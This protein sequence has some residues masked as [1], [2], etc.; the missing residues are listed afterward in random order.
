M[1]ISIVIPIYNVEAYLRECLNS[2]MAQTCPDWECILIDDASTDGS[3]AIADEFCAADSRFRLIT[4][5]ENRGL[6]EARNSGLDAAKGDYVAFIDSDDYVSADFLQ[7]SLEEIADAEIVASAFD[8]TKGKEATYSACEALS[9]MLYQRSGVNSSF[10]GKLF[11]IKLFDSLRF[12]PGRTYE[13]LDLMDRVVRR[14]R[15]VKFLNRTTYFYRQRPGSIL[16]TWS[17]KRLDVLKVTEEI[18]ARLSADPELA[19]AAR[20]RR[21]AANFNILLLLRKNGMKNSVEAQEC[22][23]RLKSLRRGVLVDSKARLKDRVGA[24]VAYLI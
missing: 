10:C 7:A 18:E 9:L 6:S 2:V 19:R 15:K 11:D 16:H 8:G 5:A 17:P 24:M 22:R 12:T 23:A 4:H 14:A 3:R 13:D 20:A 21:F 1:L